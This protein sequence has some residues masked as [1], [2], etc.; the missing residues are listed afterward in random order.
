MKPLLSDLQERVADW[1][2]YLDL[3]N[4]LQIG[5]QVGDVS[6]FSANAGHG[7][8]GLAFTMGSPDN[9]EFELCFDPRV[10][11]RDDL[12]Q[13]VVHELVHVWSF[14]QCGDD[15]RTNM[16]ALTD[17]LARLIRERRQ[18]E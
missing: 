1:R 6:E 14:S 10:E 2:K 13:I 15:P 7:D 8:D 3:P 4:R 9:T 11:G 18:V 17:E 12:D 16:E 5:V